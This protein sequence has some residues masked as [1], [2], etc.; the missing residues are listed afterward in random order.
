MLLE[1][2]YAIFEQAEPSF[3][4]IADE[5]ECSYAIFE[6]IELGYRFLFGVENLA[7]EKR[8]RLP[9]A[10]LNLRRTGR[11]VRRRV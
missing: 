4:S 3:A 9:D 7:E 6:R 5:L 1:R 2:L 8:N 11:P 10:L